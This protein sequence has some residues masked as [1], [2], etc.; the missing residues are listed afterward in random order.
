MVQQERVLGTKL[1]P[2]VGI[3]ISRETNI[4]PYTVVSKYLPHMQS[5]VSTKLY[6][7]RERVFQKMYCN[8]YE[9]I[10]CALKIRYVQLVLGKQKSQR[11]FLKPVCFIG[12]YYFETESTHPKLSSLS[13]TQIGNLCRRSILSGNLEWNAFESTFGSPCVRKSAY[14]LNNTC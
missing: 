8:G 4:H 2:E 11:E 5:K 9:G 1:E 13:C 7:K 10:A 12:H 6:V 14:M 3:Q